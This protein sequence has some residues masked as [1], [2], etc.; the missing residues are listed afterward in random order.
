M[1]HVVTYFISKITIDI[2]KENTLPGNHGNNN[3]GSIV[4][5][6]RVSEYF[7]FDQSL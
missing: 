1:L 6:T 4:L 7:S 2:N 5:I 3:N